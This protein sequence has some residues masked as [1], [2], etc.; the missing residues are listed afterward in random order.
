M[1]I[2]LDTLSL[3]LELGDNKAYKAINQYNELSFLS[4]NETLVYAWY[5]VCNDTFS[6][7]VVLN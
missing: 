1:R 4:G 7:A 6:V 5:N 2:T 3:L